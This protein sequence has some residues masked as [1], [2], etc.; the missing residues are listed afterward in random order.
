MRYGCSKFLESSE[1][2]FVPKVVQCS[3]MDFDQ[4]LTVL[5]FLI[6]EIWSILYSITFWMTWS[7]ASSSWLC[8]CLKEK[9]WFWDLVINFSDFS[10]C[11]VGIII[12]L[13]RMQFNF[14]MLY[15]TFVWF[16]EKMYIFLWKCMNSFIF[17]VIIDKIF[18]E[19][20]DIL[21]LFICF[22]IFLCV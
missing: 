15:T 14:S 21:F 22:Q 1:F 8:S 16:L 17:L 10:W 3:E 19:K 5:R 4:N 7:T 12:N 6:F 9:S 18:P 20:R 2:F 11:L 13:G